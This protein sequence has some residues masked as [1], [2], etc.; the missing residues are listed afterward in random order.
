MLDLKFEML[1]NK[2]KNKNDINTEKHFT[3]NSKLPG[4][5]HAVN[6][7]YSVYSNQILCATKLQNV[8]LSKCAKGADAMCEWHVIMNKS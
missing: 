6:I 7:L 3:I 2:N 5:A 8:T 1:K 4:N